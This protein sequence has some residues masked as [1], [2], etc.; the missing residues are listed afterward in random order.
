MHRMLR[1]GFVL[2]ACLGFVAWAGVAQAATYSV[3][4]SSQ[5]QSALGKVVA[6]DTIQLAAGTYSGSFV[7][8]RSGSKGHP[9]TLSGPAGAILSNSG[10]YGFSL[11][12][13]YWRLSGF[14]VKNSEKGVVLDGAN[15]NLLNQ[16]TVENI[17][18]EGIHFRTFSSDNV[19]QYSHIQDTGLTDPGYGEGVYIGSA[20]SNWGSLTGGKPDTS[21]NNCVAGNWIGPN[22][23]AEGVDIKEG[24]TAGIIVGNHYDATGISGENYADSFIDAKGNSYVLYGNTVK[25]P[26]KTTVI[27]DGYQTHQAY[28]GYG[29]DNLFQANTVDL[30]STGYGFNVASNTTGNVVCSD[31]K[32]TTAGSGTANVSLK[33]CS[34]A[35]PVCPKVLQQ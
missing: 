32:V 21:N 30:E 23:A 27:R 24:T 7:A 2:P 22:V 25:N 14:T 6:G 29:N 26:G 9:I 10:G 19:L 20:N 18:Q 8:T 28:T 4:S 15:H 1:S 17:D 12:A 31:N 16:L 5:L 35:R 13:D 33:S 34:G 3:S 11:Q